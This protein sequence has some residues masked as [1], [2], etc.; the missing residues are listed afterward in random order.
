VTGGPD[1][2]WY[3]DPHGS[4]QLRYWN[5]ASWTDSLAP[6]AGSGP[7]PE[8]AVTPPPQPTPLSVEARD[9]RSATGTFIAIWAVCSIAWWLMWSAVMAVIAD[10]P[11][12]PTVTLVSGL[13]FGGILAAVSYAR[14]T[15]GRLELDRG[16]DP[17]TRERL[18]VAASELGLAVRVDG[19]DVL[20][21]EP[22]RTSSLSLAGVTANV[23]DNHVGC[24]VVGGR[25]VL[26]GPK[27]TIEALRDALG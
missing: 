8:G 11:P 20:E 6:K 25:L 4:G 16:L 5:G 27:A 18:K 3:D 2:G 12:T 10:D 1:A 24:H 9:N 22:R 13:A 17:A 7:P 19:Y 26:I 14:M 23:F 15:P 21:F